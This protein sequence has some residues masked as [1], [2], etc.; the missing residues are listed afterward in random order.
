MLQ[1]FFTVFIYLACN[2]SV[3]FIDIGLRAGW[4][5]NRMGLAIPRAAQASGRKTG[6]GKVIARFL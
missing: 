4:F 1:P 3:L 5:Y 2:I 6:Y